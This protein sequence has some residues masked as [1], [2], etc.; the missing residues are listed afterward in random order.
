MYFSWV[1]LW[2]LYPE[3]GYSDLEFSMDSC[4]NAKNMKCSDLSLKKQGLIALCCREIWQK[5]LRNLRAISLK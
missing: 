2:K 5:I 4:W 3:M 1:Q